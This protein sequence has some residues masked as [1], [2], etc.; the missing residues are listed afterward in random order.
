MTS[1]PK[2]LR[3]G[4]PR[5]KKLLD[6]RAPSG[7]R[8]VLK[9]IADIRAGQ[10]SG[11]SL[12][13]ADRQRCVDY[14]SME[15]VSVAEMAEILGVDERTISRDRTE[16]RNSRAI[17]PDPQFMREMIGQMFWQ[18]EAISVRLRRV[19][20]DR[21]VAANHKIEIELGCWRIQRELFG[22]LLGAGYATP[23]TGTG[24]ESFV[25]EESRREFLEKINEVRRLAGIAPL[26]SSFQSESPSTRSLS[27]P[28]NDHGKDA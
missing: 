4:T 5:T 16:I 24:E 8:P 1:H 10:V 26:R 21:D 20:R 13:P 23:S 3:R 6:K 14:L 9:L 17:A 28:E 19:A 12:L 25:D 15:Y 18:A 2:P 7:D 11:K 22:L 27:E